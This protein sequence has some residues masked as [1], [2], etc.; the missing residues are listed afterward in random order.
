[1]YSSVQIN[2]DPIMPIGIS[3]CG[4][5]ASWAAVLTA[6]NPMYAKNTIPAP[7]MTPFQPYLPGPSAG[8]MKGCQ[9]ALLIA[10]AAAIIKR[11]TTA[12][13]MNTITLLTLADS[14]MPMTSKVVTMAMMMAAGRLKTAVTCVPSWQ[15]TSVP[16]AAE[17]AQ[18]KLMPTSCRNDTTYPD[19]PIATVT[20]PSAYSSTRSHPIIQAISSPSVA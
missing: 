4:F 17:M 2:S 13:L 11:M 8:G 3:F 5:F 10:W 18:G 12:P 20:A 6:S 7:A 15:A 9:L 14:L 1:M 19:Q 16:R